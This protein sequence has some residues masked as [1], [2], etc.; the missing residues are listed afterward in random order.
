M[1]T[2]SLEE[3]KE[4][5]KNAKEVRVLTSD[6][7]VI[8]Y[9]D[10]KDTLFFRLNAFWLKDEGENQIIVNVVANHVYYAEI[11]SYIEPTYTLTKEQL[12][13]LHSVDAVKETIEE[14]FPS[15]FP[16]LESGR[17][18]KD[19]SQPN[20]LM[21][22]DNNKI[23]GIDT[24]GNWFVRN[25]DTYVPSKQDRYATPKEVEEALTK[26]A[27]RRGYNNG[28]YKCLL[29]P[30]QSV[31][32]LGD[33]FFMENGSLWH[34]EDGN[35]NKVFSNG[36]WAEIVSEPIELTLDQ[37]AEKFGYDVKQIKIVK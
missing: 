17:W 8:N 21:F 22:V 35:A 30:R 6:K 27:V 23:Y 26:E 31:R 18:L 4:Y 1:K 29:M 15:E 9:Q 16:K 10:L 28:N 36:I 14:W 3:V 2:P 12:T 34:G 11:V 5:F 37:V 24:K 25:N 20:W 33:N 32:V 13:Y 7:K 19:N